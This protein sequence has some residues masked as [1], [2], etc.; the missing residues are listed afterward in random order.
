MSSHPASRPLSSYIKIDRTSHKPLYLQLHNSFEQAIRKGVLMPGAK[1]P[2]E[3]ELIEELGISRIV[4]R[5][6]YDA[7]VHEGLIVRER[8]RGT[9]VRATN[10]G[11]FIGKL[12]SY[13][14]ELAISGENPATRVLR[15]ER[16]LTPASL[17]MDPRLEGTAFVNPDD[18][19]CWH[20]ERI[21]RI[22]EHAHVHQDTYLPAA[23]LPG[24]DEHNFAQ[25]SLYQV[26]SQ[27]YGRRPARSHRDL[28][29]ETADERIAQLLDTDPGAAL[30]VLLNHTY[31]AKNHLVEIT[32]E[33]Y[34]GHS[35]SFEF[36]VDEDGLLRSV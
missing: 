33:R 21:R 7:L 35:V 10:Y 29:A 11:V 3:H 6:A 23:E 8:R 32:Y 34:A 2:T 15:F 18:P 14:E 13:R 25:E 9:F 24:L 4:V 28:F 1:L 26:L 30:L 20:L 16:V 31:D 19:T 17:T 27:R 36:D 22:S 5:Q 12:F